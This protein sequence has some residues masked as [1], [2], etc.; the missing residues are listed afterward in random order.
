MSDIAL[1]CPTDSIPNNTCIPQSLNTTEDGFGIKRVQFNTI[2]NPSDVAKN[3]GYLD[4]TC[5]NTTVLEGKNYVFSAKTNEPAPHNTKVWIDFNNNDTLEHPNELVLKK[6]SELNPSGEIF[7]PSD[8]VKNKPL[9]MRVSADWEMSPSPL[10]CKDLEYGQSEDYT[11]FIDTND[12]KPVAKFSV[13]DTITCDG[14]VKFKDESLNVPDSW[15]WDFGDNS[16]TSA[17][18]PSH[19]YSQNGTY[20]VK[21]KAFKNSMVDSIIK[22]DLIHVTLDNKVKPP[23]CKPKTLSYCC[24][25]GIYNV[26]LKNI[27]HSSSGG[28]EGYKDFSC[29]HR[30]QLV[31][32][33]S[34]NISIETGNSN[35]Q[36]TRVWIDLNND[37][38]FNMSKELVFEA[39]NTTD[40]SGMFKMPELSSSDSLIRMRITS[41]EVGSNLNACD[42]PKRGQTEDY[43]IIVKK[44]TG[45]ANEKGKN[46]KE[47]LLFPN[48]VNNKLNVNLSNINNLSDFTYT[49]HNILGKK[50]LHKKVSRLNTTKLVI[51]VSAFKKGVYYLTLKTS[52]YKLN[53]KFLVH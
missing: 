45:V 34:Y 3:E 9:R 4:S 36:D 41:D 32:Y 25:Y 48:P 42:D 29:E 21:F 5:M 28:E 16:Y 52:N 17:Q 8:A 40:P 51:D 35:P 18:N 38:E 31:E 24:D 50:V 22:T 10:P 2:D 7:I 33:N 43:A 19:Q 26:K 20:S 15:F 13:S 27:D 46:D 11:V 49:I 14:K 47:I 23:K 44:G 53:E 37:G 1:L 39:L 30:T 12:L 6:E